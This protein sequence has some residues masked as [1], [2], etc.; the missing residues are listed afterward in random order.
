MK[1]D[2]QLLD[3][4]LVNNYVQVIEDKEAGNGSETN[5]T[6][7]C[8]ERTET[9]EKVYIYDKVSEITWVKLLTT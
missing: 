6:S 5:T 4:I 1:K 7:G 3:P 2:F 9:T 8:G